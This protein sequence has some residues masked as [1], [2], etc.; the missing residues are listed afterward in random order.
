MNMVRLKDSE[1][2][3]G[4]CYVSIF[5]EGS[6]LIFML[7]YIDNKKHLAIDFNN[8]CLIRYSYS[9]NAWYNLELKN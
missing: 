3:I 6:P 2:Q 5:D 4:K 1:L 8:K 7:L 9:D